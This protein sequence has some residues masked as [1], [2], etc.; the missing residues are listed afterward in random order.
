MDLEA[1]MKKYDRQSNVRI[2]TGKPRLAGGDLINGSMALG[3]NQIIR[4]GWNT[5]SNRS[6]VRNPSATQ[7]S[8][9]EMFSA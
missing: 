1:V 8:F 5:S 3:G 9:R 4:S 6:A 2:W 7:A